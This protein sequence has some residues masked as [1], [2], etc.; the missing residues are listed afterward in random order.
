MIEKDGE[1]YFKPT[2]IR[3]QAR[4]AQLILR[5]DDLFEGNEVLGESDGH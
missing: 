3:F 5:F 1:K 4:F 2:E